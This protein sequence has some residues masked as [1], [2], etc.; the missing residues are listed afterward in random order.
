MANEQQRAYNARYYPS[1]RESEIERVRS[2]QRA[3]GELLN[4]LRRV[5]CADCCRCFPPHMMDFDHRDPSTKSFALSGKVQLKSE[6]T[7]LRG[8]PSVTWCART[9]IATAPSCGGSLDR[10]RIRARQGIRTPTACL[11]GTSAAVTPASRDGSKY[12]H[13]EI[14]TAAATHKSLLTNGLR[15][16]PGNNFGNNCAISDCRASLIAHLRRR[17]TRRQPCRRPR[18]DRRPRHVGSRWS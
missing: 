16:W 11:E 18:V 15:I 7:L 10:V 4:G 13:F 9:A 12:T 3:A 2:R 1:H 8:S 17:A 6:E 14:K 5:P